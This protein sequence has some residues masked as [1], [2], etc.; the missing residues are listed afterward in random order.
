[1]PTTTRLNT[2]FEPIVRAALTA[3]TT[4][5]DAIAHMRACADTSITDFAST[6]VAA[7]PTAAAAAMT[8]TTSI[9]DGDTSQ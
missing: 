8:P 7:S 3:Q 2:D 5:A 4:M 1:M 9:A 6:I